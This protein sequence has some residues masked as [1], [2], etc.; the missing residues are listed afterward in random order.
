MG[1]SEKVLNG[2]WRREERRK[3]K[4]KSKRQKTKDKRL[5]NQDARIK[6]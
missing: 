3:D 4:N 6:Q 1:V 2:I 5:K